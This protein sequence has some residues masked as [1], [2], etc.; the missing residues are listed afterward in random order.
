MIL[1]QLRM[2]TGYRQS[3]AATKKQDVLLEPHESSHCGGRVLDAFYGDMRLGDGCKGAELFGRKL[4][5]M[6]SGG[7]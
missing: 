2:Q 7:L 6:P 5:G 4:A 3:L 1:L